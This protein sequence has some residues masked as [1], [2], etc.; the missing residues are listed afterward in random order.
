MNTMQ[1][2]LSSLDHMTHI[3]N[4]DSIFQN[5]LL[6][7]NNPYKRKDISN[8]EVNN[9]RTKREYIYGKSLHSYVPLYFNPRNAMM[10]KNRNENIVILSFDTILLRKQGVLFTN[11]NASTNSVKYY[12]SVQYLKQLNW[13]YIMAQSWYGKIEEVKQVMMAEVLVPNKI[14]IKYLKGIYCKD[15]VTKEMLLKRYNLKSHQVAVKPY[16]FFKGEY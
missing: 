1:P 11:K 16:L 8:T 6:A 14:N 2:K 3:D 10:Y 9:R 15:H 7:H 5:G 13:E 4:L 12:Q